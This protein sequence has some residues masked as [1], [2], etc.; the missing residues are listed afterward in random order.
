MD[1]IYERRM[2]QMSSTIHAKPDW[3]EALKNAETC[4]VW[5]AEAKAKELTDIEFRYVLDELAYYSLLHSP[6]SNARLSAAAGVWFSD[7]L[8]A[9]EATNELKE[10]AI[11]LK[12]IPE[13]LKNWHPSVRSRV[14]N[15]VDPSLFPLIYARSKLCCQPCTSLQ[16]SL[17]PSVPG[18]FP[19]SLDKWHG[20]LSGSNY[21]L[22]TIV[23]RQAL[24]ASDKLN[25]LPSEFRVDDNGAV[26][27]ESYINNL[28]PI[29]HAPLYPIIAGVF[30]K[31]L[32]L[33]EQVITDLVHPRKPRVDFYP[34][35]CYDYGEPKPWRRDFR[36]YDEYLGAVKAWKE[37]ASY[38]DPQPKP[39]ALPERPISPYSLCGR[40]LQA[41]VKMSNI[42]LTSKNPNYGGEDWDV[43][44]LANERIIATGIFFYD[45][46]NIAESS[47][48]FCEAL[49]VQCLEYEPGDADAISMVY[50]IDRDLVY[51]GTSLSE[52]VGGVA[53]KDGRCLVFPNTL[54]YFMPE[55]VLADGTKPG[56]C[57]ML[58]FYFVDPSTRIPSTEIVPPQQKDWWI[59]DVLSS[60]PFRSMPH[61]IVDG[62]MGKIEY[63]ISLKEAKKIRQEMETT[64]VE[65]KAELSCTLYDVHYA[66]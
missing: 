44:G 63:P 30:S 17:N 43:V 32:P 3:M 16:A 64:V 61:L 35:N 47:L 27:V 9:A 65:I 14:L 54:Q 26:T 56:H 37:D 46:A 50:G 20:A 4:A 39:F 15:L 12:S 6:G 23:K 10:Y 62:I 40:R 31:L 18:E 52:E 59:E 36:S 28:H 34:D 49:S 11:L 42:E 22:P 51:S 53:I 41:I 19:G 38:V 1:T 24:H 33:L 21:Y 7:T 13:C 45:V 5:A 29:W 48:D 58:T 55:L 60:E 8:I 66:M 25:W 2:R 57:K